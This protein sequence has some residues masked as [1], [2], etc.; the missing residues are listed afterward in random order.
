MV[1][2]KT[3]ILIL[4]T[5]TQISLSIN[6]KAQKAK[7]A[8]KTI[9]PLQAPKHHKPAKKHSKIKKKAKSKPI[10]PKKPKKSKKKAKKP[11]KPKKK[12]KKQKKPKKP[13]KKKTKK[14]KKKKPEPF[15]PFVPSDNIIPK[16]TTTNNC[17]VEDCIL[18]ANSTTSLCQKCSNQFM[19]R[20]I[21]SR[22]GRRRF[23]H[24]CSSKQTYGFYFAFFILPILTIFGIYLYCALRDPKFE[25]MLHQN[26][27]EMIKKNHFIEMIK[28][29]EGLVDEDGAGYFG[30]DPE[31]LG[32]IAGEDSVYG[33]VN[34]DDDH[35]SGTLSS[36][37]FSGSE[38]FHGGFEEDD[39]I[40]NEENLAALGALNSKKNTSGHLKND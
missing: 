5:L 31:Q 25:E 1:K 40:F 29:E 12:A 16:V 24:I 10:V 15:K 23:Y 38:S 26:D 21:T 36:S 27:M 39:P 4:I 22:Y 2:S 9:A 37:D 35:D 33:I 7:K 3:L 11:K 30:P 19:L 17:R 32:L 8:K 6:K 18:C 13:K 14:K 20:T 34:M 28:K